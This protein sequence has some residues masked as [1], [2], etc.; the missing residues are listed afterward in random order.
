M[1]PYHRAT[2]LLVLLAQ[3]LAAR[4]PRGGPFPRGHRP[5]KAQKSAIGLALDRPE[6]MAVLGLRGDHPVDRRVAVGAVARREELH[7]RG[8]G[9]E[10]EERVAIGFA[11]RPQPQ[12]LGLDHAPSSRAA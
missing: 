7:H 4:Q 8:I 1:T 12:S 9:V 3:L 2:L 6:A 10:R 5:A 11:P